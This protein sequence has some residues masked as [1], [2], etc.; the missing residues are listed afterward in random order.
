MDLSKEVNWLSK[1]NQSAIATSEKESLNRIKNSVLHQKQQTEQIKTKADLYDK[2]ELSEIENENSSIVKTAAKCRTPHQ[3]RIAAITYARANVDKTKPASGGY[4]TP[5][6]TTL[7]LDCTNFIS[8]C[9]LAGEFGEYEGRHL[10]S[11][12]WFYNN[13]SDRSSSW[14]GVIALYQYISWNKTQQGGPKSSSIISDSNFPYT[15]TPRSNYDVN[16]GDIIQI[17]S[18]RSSRN[19][20]Q[21]STLVGGFSRGTHPYFTD[22]HITHRTGPNVYGRND[23]LS[24]KYP[25]SPNSNAGSGGWLYRK[26]K[27]KYIGE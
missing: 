2:R 6:S 15:Y 8:H 24:E 1:K 7:G 25:P 12:C 13:D 23:K 4:G 27:L 10:H 18:N 5:Y 22:I 3:R 26:I 9:L 14:A 11:D 16:Y 19:D 17:K 20:Y 21:H